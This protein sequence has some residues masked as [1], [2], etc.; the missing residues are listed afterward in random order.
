MKGVL[1]DKFTVLSAYI[2]NEEILYYQ[3]NS[4]P[5]TLKTKKLKSR[6]KYDGI[7]NKI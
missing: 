1:G 5:E 7:N 4:I 3:L 2:K 6:H